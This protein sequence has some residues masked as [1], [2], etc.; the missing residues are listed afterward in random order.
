MKFPRRRELRYVL[1]VKVKP[2]DFL[3]VACTRFFSRAITPR[4]SWSPFTAA[5]RYSSMNTPHLG[6][7]EQACQLALVGNDAYTPSWSALFYYETKRK[8]Q[9]GV[10][11][12]GSNQ[13]GLLE[14]LTPFARNEMSS[15]RYVDLAYH[16]AVS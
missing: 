14:L 6:V 1:T 4:F 13:D 12:G 7:N 5:T 11:E 8:R 15:S 2:Q 3:V 16:A 9:E 10:G